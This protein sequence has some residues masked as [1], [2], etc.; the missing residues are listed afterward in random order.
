MEG[1]PAVLVDA[2]GLVGAPQ[3][4]AAEEGGE[5]EDAVVPLGAGAGHVEL[6]EEPVEV[7]EGGGE[8]VEDEGGAV[9]VHE[10]SL[11]SPHTNGQYRL[12][13]RRRRMEK[14]WGRRW[15]VRI[16]RKTP[17]AQ[18][19]HASTG[20]PRKHSYTSDRSADPRENTPRRTPGSCPPLPY[21]PTLFPANPYPYA[22]HR[23][24]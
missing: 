17:P 13:R 19:P 6:I 14:T 3:E 20:P 9:V 1:G 4:T 21:T 15:H 18:Q 23:R 16:Q 12:C 5:E 8:L 2:Q 22:L 11:R 7:E 10:G 24:R